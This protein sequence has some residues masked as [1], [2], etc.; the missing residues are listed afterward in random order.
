MTR[1]PLIGITPGPSTT[2]P[3]RGSLYR[4]CLSDNYVKAVWQ[5]GGNPII[6]PWVS[7]TP[8][9]ILDEIDGLV[10]S[11]GGDIMPSR[12]GQERHEQTDGIDEARDEFELTL[13]KAAAERDLPTLAICRGIQVMNVAFGGTLIQHIPDVSTELQ[14][15]Q[16]EIDVPREKPSHSVTLENVPN[17]ISE[18]IGASELMTN[19]FHHQSIAEIAPPLR[20]AGRS[21]DGIIE[22]V[23]HTG[24]AFGIGVQWHPEGLAATYPEH[25]RLFSALVEATRK[26]P[27]PV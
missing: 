4:Y 27:A 16:D 23:W 1:R 22:A 10:L 21:D 15:R 14:H 26:S 24:M 9:E 3:D 13:M 19:S 17:S 7:D 5:G 18:I 6:L 12:F 11:G 8:A 2:S 25:A 20:L